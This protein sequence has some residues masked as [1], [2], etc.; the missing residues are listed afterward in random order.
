[1]SFLQ[2]LR[3]PKP[4]EDAFYGVFAFIPALIL[5][6]IVWISLHDG[7]FKLRGGNYV[8]RESSPK[9]FWFL[10][11]IFSIMSTAAFVLC[12]YTIIKISRGEIAWPA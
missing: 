4:G 10:I 5:G 6:F 3:P 7:C 11:S 9:Y 12:V 2:I 8:Y 1:M